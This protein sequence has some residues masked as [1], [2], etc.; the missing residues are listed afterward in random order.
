LPSPEALELVL[1]AC[2]L[3]V[4]PTHDLRFLLDHAAGG[5]LEVPGAVQESLWL[6]PWSVELRYGDD[7]DEPLDHA[8]AAG[9]VRAV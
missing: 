1:A 8:A 7:L 2:G 5:G 6:T 3:G 9:T 4:P